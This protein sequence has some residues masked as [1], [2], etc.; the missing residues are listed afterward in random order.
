M[1]TKTPK[2]HI[3][4]FYFKHFQIKAIKMWTTAGFALKCYVN[5]GMFINIYEVFHV[6][7]KTLQICEKK[8]INFLIGEIEMIFIY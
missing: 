4:L 1:S 2:P 8:E 6:L 3:I 7:L 5:I